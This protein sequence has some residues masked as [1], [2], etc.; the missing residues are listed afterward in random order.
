M[1][2]ISLDEED[3]I[4]GH[5]KSRRVLHGIARL[6]LKHTTQSMD[7]LDTIYA[8]MTCSELP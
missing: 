8:F 3:C 6:L 4:S 5:S 2:G 1:S 7:A